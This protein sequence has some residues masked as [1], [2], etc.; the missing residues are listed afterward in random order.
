MNREPVT[1]TNI[2]SIGYDQ[3][4]NILEVEFNSGAV[5]QYFDV[6]EYVWRELMDATSHGS[7]LAQNIKGVYSYSR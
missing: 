4:A 1:S 5:Y 6:P 3:D 7:F 2:S